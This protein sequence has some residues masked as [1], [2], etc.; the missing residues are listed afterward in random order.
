MAVTF[1]PR[2]PDDY[3][4]SH[5]TDGY[6]YVFLMEATWPDNHTPKLWEISD[7]LSERYGPMGTGWQHYYDSFWLRDDDQA[8]EFKLRW[9]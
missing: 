4:P 6:P 1:Y 5:W 7:W 9:L 2:E 8:M 3:P